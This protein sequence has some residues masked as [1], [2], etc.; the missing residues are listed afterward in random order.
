VIAFSP[1]PT[2]AKKL[3]CYLFL[4]CILAFSG[5]YGSVLLP[6]SIALLLY[7]G[8]L[9]NVIFLSTIACLSALYILSAES[10]MVTL[11]NIFEPDVRMIFLSYLVEHILLLGLFGRVDYSIGIGVIFIAIVPLLI[12]RKDTLFVKMSL[13]FIA[14]SLA[15]FIS[16]FLSA[17]FGQYAGKVISSHTVIAQFC[18]LLFVLLCVD[19]FANR[20]SNKLS[21]SAL[22]ASIVVAFSY[23]IITKQ[24]IVA[25]YVRLLPDPKLQGYLKAVQYAKT[26]PIKDNDFLQL[27]HIDRLGFVTSFHRGNG[28]KPVPESD[29]PDYVKPFYITTDLQRKQKYMFRY[30]NKK[31]VINVSKT[32]EQIAP[33]PIIKPKH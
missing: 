12:Y 2:S 1:P 27:L 16:Y 28:S 10:G 19:R 29:L 14:T 17:K 32:G 18:W 4:V 20:L 5:P 11:S 21:I 33:I 31:S 13:I 23:V 15:S 7:F 25:D 6:L 3:G 8:T 26:H 24:S 22:S 9:R 30:S